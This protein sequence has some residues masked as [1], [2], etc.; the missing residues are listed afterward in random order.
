MIPLSD[1]LKWPE[2]IQ[3]FI[4]MGL[5]SYQSDK[6]LS[7]SIKDLSQISTW[8][9]LSGNAA[10][11]ALRAGHQTLDMDSESARELISHAYK[12]HSASLDVEKGIR[13]IVQFSEEAPKILVD[14]DTNQVYPPNTSHLDPEKD[15]AEIKKIQEKYTLLQSRVKTAEQALGIVDQDFSRVMQYATGQSID[16]LPKW[17]QPPRIHG[18]AKVQIAA[19]GKGFA[20]KGDEDF[21]LPKQT[22]KEH[23]DKWGAPNSGIYK[24]ESGRAITRSGGK[25]TKIADP[26]GPVLWGDEKEISRQRGWAEGEYGKVNVGGRD[27]DYRWG[28]RGPSL[29]GKAGLEGYEKGLEGKLGG[30]VN[31]FSNDAEARTHLGPIDIT[32][33]AEQKLGVE[34]GTDTTLNI[35]KNGGLQGGGDVFAGYSEKKGI[36]ADGWGIHFKD[37][38]TGYAGAGGGLGGHIGQTEDGKWAL[39]WNAGLAFGVGGKNHMEITVDPSE[40]KEHLGDMWQWLSR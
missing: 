9:G 24:D 15:A 12:V 39:G 30:N 7:Q 29:D 31:I 23:D 27:I 21:P 32:T 6:T 28:A 17:R 25:S 35:D 20:P 1:G 33:T 10:R 14:L 5:K 38:V 16:P 13:N 11:N 3:E 2:Y 8:E 40:V 18:A 19:A 37:D 34:V 4:D 26:K 22:L 36:D